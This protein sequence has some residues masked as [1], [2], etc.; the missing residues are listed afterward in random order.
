MWKCKKCGREFAKTNQSHSCVNYPIENH[1]HNKGE[2]P[3]QLFDFFVKKIEKEIGPITIESL[4]CCIHLV[5]NY[6][7]CGVWITREKIKFDFRLDYKIT[8]KRIKKEEILSKN[9]FIYYFEI[10][11]SKSIDSTLLKWIKDAYNL[12]VKK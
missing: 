10:G 9:R 11:D 5:S 2:Y 7:F 4:P 8:D 1:F 3:K 6:T 12:N